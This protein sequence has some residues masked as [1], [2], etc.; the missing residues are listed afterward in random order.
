VKG[1][2]YSVEALEAVLAA[3][4]EA[5]DRTLARKVAVPW[6]VAAAV[7]HAE[8]VREVLGAQTAVRIAREARKITGRKIRLALRA[9]LAEAAFER[10][11][12]SPSLAR[13]VARR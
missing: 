12:T 11:E 3:K 2:A 13:G 4:Q 5:A 10:A 6:D 7:S 8:A 9:A 1:S